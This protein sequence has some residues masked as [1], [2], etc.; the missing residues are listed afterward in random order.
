MLVAPRYGTA[1][2]ADV[3]PALLAALSVAGEDDRI[4][5]DLGGVRRLCMLL[6]DG[7]GAEALA[8]HP[9]EA[10]FLASL[11]GPTLTA[12]F[13]S[14]T[15]ASLGSLGTGRPPGEHGIVGY[16]LA[17]PGHERA[18]NALQ[19][20]LHGPGPAVDLLAELVPEQFQP[21]PTAFE[22][23]EAAGIRVTRLGPAF[24]GRSGLTR[25][26]L[27]GGQFRA[28]HSAGDL[29]AEAAALLREDGPGLVYAYHGDLDLTGHLRGPR[30]DAWMLDLVNVDRLSAAIA[31]RLPADAALVVT[32]DHGMVEV[33]E[34]LDLESAP[35]L[36]DGVRL[37][38]G[39]PRARHVYAQDGAAP[40]VLAAW[41]SSI[42]DGFAV[43]SRDEAIAS[44]WFG[45]TVTRQS[46]HTIGD[47]VAV[48][49]GSG[50]LVRRGA[51]PLQSSLIGHHGSLT[52][53]EMMVP[54]LVARS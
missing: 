23:A 49:G 47:V 33:T 51:E 37:V 54:L 38:G 35:G 30:S 53:R 25:A 44:G 40:D 2:L 39:E 48:A 19:W 11:A 21:A 46:R 8:E 31:D 42:G 13:P 24:H 50:A 4:G 15:A 17:V 29:A 36:L 34:R 41:Q 10:P 14:T 18:M 16:L 26:A 22:R 9:G 32:A 1:S 7:L 12:G 3:V 45:P 28:S 52:S 20:R 43:L 27:R 6:V 5:L